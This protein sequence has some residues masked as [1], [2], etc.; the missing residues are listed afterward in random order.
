MQWITSALALPRPIIEHDFSA[1]K[2]FE[3]ESREHVQAEAEACNINQD[4]GSGEV[5]EDVALSFGAE[6]NEAR[7][8]HDEACEE[9]HA[10][11]YV[12]YESEAVQSRGFEGSVDE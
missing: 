9:G 10:C 5:V 4:V 3:G 11:T 6:C 2:S 7:E 12:G 1:D 8:G